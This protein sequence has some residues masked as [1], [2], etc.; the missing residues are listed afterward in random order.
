MCHP[1]TGVGQPTDLCSSRQ[2]ADRLPG[3]NANRAMKPQKQE[4]SQEGRSSWLYV[5]A[6]G[7]M[8][9]ALAGGLCAGTRAFAQA[10]DR[11]HLID[12][13]FAANISDQD[14][15]WL[16]EEAAKLLGTDRDA[17]VEVDRLQNRASLL[18]RI[19]TEE[20]WQISTRLR[21][22]ISSLMKSARGADF[23]NLAAAQQLFFDSS[24]AFDALRA[25]PDKKSQAFLSPKNAGGIDDISV[26]WHG[27]LGRHQERRVCKIVYT[28]R[29]HCYETILDREQRAGAKHEDLLRAWQLA[30]GSRSHHIRRVELSQIN[31]KNFDKCQ[32]WGLN[33]ETRRMDEEKIDYLNG[34]MR[35]VKS[36]LIEDERLRLSRSNDPSRYCGRP[37]GIHIPFSLPDEQV[38]QFVQQS[39][40]V[41]CKSRR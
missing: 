29:A 5:I 3:P 18:L 10:S 37:F 1:Y 21:E 32:S 34:V 36:C 15:I 17:S 6:L 23:E 19:V 24:L 33:A 26:T 35:A 9:S 8:A 4:R 13:E 39:T 20:R 7:C 40:L 22:D 2:K 30:V 12:L 25:L 38:R 11:K 31:L 27:E 41:T 14:R 28:Q 16:R